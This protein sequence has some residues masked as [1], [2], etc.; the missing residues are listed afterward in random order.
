MFTIHHVVQ[1]ETKMGICGSL[2]WLKGSPCPR[3]NQLLF[4]ALPSPGFSPA[5]WELL[6][7]PPSPVNKTDEFNIPLSPA[8]SP[9]SWLQSAG[10]PS[11]L[12]QASPIRG[13]VCRGQTDRSGEASKWELPKCLRQEPIWRGCHS[14][15]QAVCGIHQNPV[16]LSST[17]CQCALKHF[18]FNLIALRALVNPPVCDPSMSDSLLFQKCLC[19][20]PGEGERLLGAIIG[21]IF[22]SLLIC[23]TNIYPACCLAME[24]NR[25][26]GCLPVGRPIKKSHSM[27]W[28][29]DI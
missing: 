10:P 29:P 4:T 20:E 1:F 21:Q 15:C 25:G 3:P 5:L 11:R 26:G 14:P 8:D 13:G 9:K 7:P 6:P 17:P 12:T 19:P 22:T 23:P 24:M 16:G 27:K 28:H 18:P 2:I